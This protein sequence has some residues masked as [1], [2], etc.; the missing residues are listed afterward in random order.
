MSREIR[1]GRLAA[2][3]LLE[4]AAGWHTLVVATPGGTGR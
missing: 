1:N 4:R 2:L 3:R